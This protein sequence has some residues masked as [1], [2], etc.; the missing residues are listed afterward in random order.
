MP[1]NGQPGGG[2]SPLQ[3][4]QTDLHGFREGWAAWESREGNEERTEDAR[5]LGGAERNREGHTMRG[6]GDEGRLEDLIAGLVVANE[7]RGERTTLEEV[8]ITALDEWGE[9][10]F[11]QGVPDTFPGM[12]AAAERLEAAVRCITTR[13]GA[14]I[15]VSPHMD[16][17]ARPGRRRVLMTPSPA[18]R[19]HEDEW[20]SQLAHSQDIRD[21]GHP[22]DGST[23][24]DGAAL[25]YIDDVVRIDTQRVVDAHSRNETIAGE[26]GGQTT[27]GRAEEGVTGLGDAERQGDTNH[28]N[29]AERARLHDAGDGEAS[30]GPVDHGGE[31]ERVSLA[32][33]NSEVSHD[34][35][36]NAAEWE[37]L[38]EERTRMIQEALDHHFGRIGEMMML[39]QDPIPVATE[40]DMEYID[41][42]IGIQPARPIVEDTVLDNGNVTREDRQ[43]VRADQGDVAPDHGRRGAL[44]ESAGPVIA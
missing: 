6:T 3:E 11:P 32:S 39:D 25:I 29:Q 14:R 44:I 7:R 15:S 35:R 8:L 42:S 22:A 37:V 33:D 5:I 31:H 4:A 30:T 2:S 24:Q 36:G 19:R 20:R 10:L 16:T 1:G 43:L 34:S 12:V 9:D 23:P 41:R 28:E 40:V 13:R 27:T 26:P 21:R 18:R 17:A 38:R